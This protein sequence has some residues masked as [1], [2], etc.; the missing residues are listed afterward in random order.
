MDVATGRRENVLLLPSRAVSLI[1]DKHS[2]ILLLA[3][4]SRVETQVTVG[5]T[6][7]GLTEIAN[8]L[9]EGQRVVVPASD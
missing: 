2:V 6:S 5:R 8:G 1:G 3:D 9:T 4:N 7:G